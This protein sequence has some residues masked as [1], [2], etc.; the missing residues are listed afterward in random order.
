MI[1]MNN[2]KKKITFIELLKIV[3]KRARLSTLILLLIT[4][5]STTFAWFV[6]A[7][8][9]SAGI[10]AHIESWNILFTSK[11][12]MISEYVNFVIPNMYP[13]MPDY[14]DGV[15]AYNLGEKQATIY[16]E[17]VSATIL[18]V[19]YVVD[20]TTL[21]SD[22]MINKLARDYPFKISLSL[23]NES[24]T[25]NSGRTYFS[26]NVTWP[27]ESG[28]DELDTF[29]GK[30]AFDYN[31]NNPDSPSIELVVKISAIQSNS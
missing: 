29:W 12:N 26:L 17:V 2:S 27:F 10:T 4:F 21:T 7:T 1:I 15:S 25:P 14:D 13:G 9:I 11:D 20:E 16:F 31:S 6:Y 8:K 18:G 3:F 24:L 28:N 30:K 5:S 22:M 19:R 23:S